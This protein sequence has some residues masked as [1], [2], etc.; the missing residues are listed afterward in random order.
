M[1]STIKSYFPLFLFP[2]NLDHNHISLLHKG[3]FIGKYNFKVWVFLPLNII[4]SV[5]SH[6]DTDKSS[7]RSFLVPE[8]LLS[9]IIRHAMISNCG[10][11]QKMSSFTSFF[12]S[13]RLLVSNFSH[14]RITCR[15]IKHQWPG[16]ALRE[17]L[18]DKLGEAKN[19]QLQQAPR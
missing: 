10:V 2:S 9:S 17:F 1:P 12:L 11:L 4:S 15:S 14:L 6:K 18:I 7:K 13:Q 3:I 8:R 16:P 19:L 5:F